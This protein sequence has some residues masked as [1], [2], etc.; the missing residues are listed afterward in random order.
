VTDGH[1]EAIYLHGEAAAPMRAVASVRAVSGCGLEGDRYWQRA[2][3]PNPPKKAGPDREVTLIEAEALEGL[4]RESGIALEPSQS[5]RNIVTRGVALNHLVEREFRVGGATLK[6]LRLC[7][8]CDH[9]QSL[10]CQGVITGL[11]HRGGLRAQILTDGIVQV[12][13]LVAV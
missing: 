13:D 11:L 7:E 3:A 8:P 10:T 4:R 5:R 12:G 1:V 9:L 2:D 6:G